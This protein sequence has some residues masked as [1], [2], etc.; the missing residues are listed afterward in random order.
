MGT[1]PY[2]SLRLRRGNGSP[3]DDLYALAAT[4]FYALTKRDPFMYDGVYHEERGL[5]CR[6]EKKESF[7]KLSEFLDLAVAGEFATAM[8]AS[9]LLHRLRAPQA[10]AA[11][12][13]ALADEASSE[14]LRPQEVGRLKDILMTYPGS[15]RWGNVETRGLDSDFARDTYVETELDRRLYEAVST[16]SVGLVVLCGNAGD[17]K[18][19]ILQ[20]LAKSLG[21]AGATSAKQ[22]GESHALGRVNGAGQSG[23]SS[24]VERSLS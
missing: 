7:P 5:A 18:T 16:G 1:P 3:R 21:I 17:G 11:V 12:S 19:S 2:S 10:D 4:F 13:E 22:S 24:F 14:V 15:P 6:P 20:H 9:E 8:E 23:R